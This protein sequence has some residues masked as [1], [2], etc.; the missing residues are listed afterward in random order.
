[1]A[2]LKVLRALTEAARWM[3]HHLAA[4]I[5]F[6]HTDN[7]GR[8]PFERMAH[9]G[10]DYNT[11]EGENIAAG[12]RTAFETF[13]QWKDSPD[14]N[15]NMLDPAYKVIG[16]GMVH[17]HGSEYG[18]YWVTDFGGYVDELIDVDVGRNLFR[19]YP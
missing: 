11:W 19:P 8:D 14:H 3:S 10:Y 12:N 17:R 18:Y 15:E 6:D 4:D 16:I 7:Y 13:L 5:I 9:F 1:M 2:P